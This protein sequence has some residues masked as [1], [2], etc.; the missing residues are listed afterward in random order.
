[1][2]LEV[3]PRSLTPEPLHRP[4]SEGDASPRSPCHCLILPDVAARDRHCSRSP[5]SLPGRGLYVLRRCLQATEPLWDPVKFVPSTA[6]D[7]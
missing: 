6:D 5:P 7:I 2:E 4:E 3:E 1:M